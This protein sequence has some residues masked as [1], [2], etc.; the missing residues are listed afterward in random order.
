[1]DFFAI[2]GILLSLMS[3]YSAYSDHDLVQLLKS[4]D[5]K[6]FTEIYHRYKGVMYQHAYRRLADE[7]EVDDVVQ[8]IFTALWTKRDG[9][10]EET[11]LGGFLYVT[12]RN[13]IINLASRRQMVQK[14]EDTLDKISEAGNAITDHKVRLE[15]LKQLIEKEV[16]TLPP[17]MREIFEYSRNQHLSH[18]EIAEKLNISEKTVKNQIN[19]ALKVLRGK[20]GLFIYLLLLLRII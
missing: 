11:N 4:G 7:D 19:N 17:K 8:D 5:E 6:S 20:F 1:L 12:L 13:K 16:S 3:Y 9:L 10:A 15:L 14:Y 2:F 18:K